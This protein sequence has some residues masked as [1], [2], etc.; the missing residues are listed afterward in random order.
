MQCFSFLCTLFS[1][2][3]SQ[4][5]GGSTA[6]LSVGGRTD[7]ITHETFIRKLL[8]IFVQRWRNVGKAVYCNLWS[9][10]TVL[11]EK[12]N[13]MQ[14]SAMF[15]NV[16]QYFLMFFTFLLSFPD[17]SIWDKL[18]QITEQGNGRGIFGDVQKRKE[19]LCLGV[20]LSADPQKLK[21]I[22]FLYY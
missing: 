15:A 22:V 9:E 20:W 12:S 13:R 11:A 18:S 17:D 4:I 16:F 14:C 5:Y 6:T 8:H 2:I 7:W 3:A 10:R 21:T 19:K 1:E